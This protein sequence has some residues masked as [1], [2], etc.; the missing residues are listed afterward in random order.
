MSEKRKVNKKFI[1]IM[2][3]LTVLIVISLPYILP[4]IAG[5]LFSQ[6]SNLFS[7]K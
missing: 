4:K 6:D 2:I 3:S 5:L 1:F 7:A